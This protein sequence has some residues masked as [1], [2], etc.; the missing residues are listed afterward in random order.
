[1][2]KKSENF[3]KLTENICKN[4]NR[5]K[6]YKNWTEIYPGR[7]QQQTKW[8]KLK[9]QWATRHGSGT[10]PNREAKRKKE[11][12]IMWRYFKGPMD[13][14]QVHQHWHFSSPKRRR[15]NGKESLF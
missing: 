4:T 3:N 6:Y 12:K 9:D 14:Y 5:A 13:Q 7:G 11:C 2:S 8:S 15:E 1:M 10:H